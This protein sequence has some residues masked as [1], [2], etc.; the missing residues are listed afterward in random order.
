MK[1]RALRLYGKNDLRLEEFELP[2]IK[3]DEILALVVSDS[4]CMSSYKAMLQGAD[5]KR[6]PN[7]VAER[8][9]II[10]HEFCGK[11]VKVGK[12]WANKFRA[13]EKFSIQPALNYKGRI[14]SIGYSY[15]YAGGDATYI[16]IPNEA[17]EMDCLLPYNGDGYFGGSIAEPYSCVADAFHAMY[18][19]VPGKY[20]H[21][22]GV[23]KGG[24]MAIL[25]GA[26]PMGLAAIDYIIHADPRPSKLVVT[27]IDQTRLDRAASL[28]STANPPL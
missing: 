13:G 9:I 11:L 7:D 18:H 25:A 27:D 4:L 12:K 2:E 28:L 22:M 26:G 10:G 16:I 24:K 23:K 8:P 5:H 20:E 17:M 15:Q 1:T 6:V 3:D 21:I 14:D 19:T